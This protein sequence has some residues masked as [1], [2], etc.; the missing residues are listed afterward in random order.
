MAEDRAMEILGSWLAF[1]GQGLS[2]KVSVGLGAA[3]F[4]ALGFRAIWLLVRPAPKRV[5]GYRTRGPDAVTVASPDQN[6]VLARSIISRHLLSRCHLR[7][8]K[9]LD[10]YPGLKATLVQGGGGSKSIN[11][12][13][14]VR[15]A[16]A[17]LSAQ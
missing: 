5:S 3:Y 15:V 17:G 7:G 9:G 14:A 13:R 12:Q 11:L 8:L 4:A 16:E 6:S 1:E 2:M 10:L